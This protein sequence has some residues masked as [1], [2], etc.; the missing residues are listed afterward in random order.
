MIARIWHGRTP[1][2]KAEEYL[3]FLNQRAIP[4]YEAISGNRGSYVLRRLEDDE[5]HFLT[6]TF[7]ESKAAVERFAGSD[8][9]TAKYYPEDESFLL[10]FEPAVKHYEVFPTEE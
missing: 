1:T 5:A 3:E 8:I 2:E 6:L 9:E 7:W 4:D 10:E